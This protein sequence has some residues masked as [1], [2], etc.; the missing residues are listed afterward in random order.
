MVTLMVGAMIAESE[1][2][3]AQPLPA[4]NGNWTYTL[5]QDSQLTDDCPICDRIPIVVPLRGKFELRLLE[6]NPVFA[7]YAVENL[8]FVASE[9]LRPTYKVTGQGTYQVGGEVAMMQEMVLEVQIDNG[10]T[11]TLC[12]LTNETGL[13]QRRW[14]MMSIQLHQTNGTIAQVYHLELA[15]APLHEIWF[16][17]QHGFHSGTLPPVPSQ[18]TGG[19]L[20]SS[21]GRLVK[22][23]HELTARL[24]IMPVV[25][26]LGLDAIDI[27]PGGEIAFSMAQGEFSETLGPLH[28]GDVLSDRGKVIHSYADLM[29]AFGPQPPLADSGLDALHRVNEEEF[30]FS[31]KQDFFSE[32]LGRAIHRG[33][34]LSSRGVILKTNEELLAPF[35][36]ADPKKDYGL[37]AVWVWPNGEIW[38]STEEGVHGQHFEFYAPGDLLSDQGYVVFRNLELVGAFAPL[39]DLGD[40]GLDALFIV[41]DASPSAPAPRFT[42]VN[43]GP[44]TGVIEL[45]WDGAGRV[46]QVKR[47]GN[48]AGPYSPLS[49]IVPDLFFNDTTSFPPQSFYRL[50]QW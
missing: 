30:C 43:R 5:L 50:R 8:D 37:D 16:S 32:I 35:N 40:F 48:A 28:E 27:L 15:A 17:T 26:D 21:A 42:R 23:N 22:R 4:T 9:P 41:S 20:I 1:R 2:V 7:R 33:D 38:F 10:D 49:E 47:A 46:F 24:G 13:V 6:E 18:V 25:P 39:E 36:P 34:L 44:A 29:G 45:E 14:P 11:K 3:A 19:D 31:I 12:Y